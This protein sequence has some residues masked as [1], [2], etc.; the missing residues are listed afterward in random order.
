M[1]TDTQN[2]ND[3]IELSELFKIL[4]QNI[5]LIVIVSLIFTVGGF[6]FTKFFIKPQYQS[7]AT[8]I[9]NNRRDE[10]SN[11]TTDEM[12]TAR[13]LAGVYS[14][15]IKSDSVLS[16]VIDNLNLDLE[17]EALSKK[18]TVAAVDNTQVMRITVK[19]GNAQRAQEIASELVKVSPEFIVEM[20][21]AG[22]VKV[23]SDAKLNE[24]RVSPNLKMN[25]LVSFVLGMMLSVGYILVT[26]MLDRTFKSESDIQQILEIP[27]LGI[28]PN[29]DSVRD[30]K[31]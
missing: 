23:I 9:V 15:I 29:V 14:I 2:F 18:I 13:N 10:N 20:V 24:H 16:Q 19:D 6:L 25:V 12:N 22:S 26:H 7:Q 8:L 21:E 31:S 11:I 5:K 17:A 4:K 27:V 30:V 3:E 28:I 1:N